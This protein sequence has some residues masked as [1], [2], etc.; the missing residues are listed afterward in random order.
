MHILR[1]RR[2][3]LRLPVRGR[4][5]GINRCSPEVPS[6]RGGGCGGGADRRTDGGPERGGQA[7]ASPGGWST[8]RSPPT[9]SWPGRSRRSP[10]I[11]GIRSVSRSPTRRDRRLRARS[12]GWR[13]QTT[14][15]GRGGP[16]SSSRAAAFVGPDRAA[17]ASVATRFSPTG[18]TGRCMYYDYEASPPQPFTN[19]EGRK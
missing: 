12:V 19:W 3:S 6:V 18:P 17:L 8:W 1:R 14:G 7:T 15:G 13:S 2:S 4:Q 5:R 9:T 16:R 10:S 11:L